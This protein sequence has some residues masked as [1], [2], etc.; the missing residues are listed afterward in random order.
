MRILSIVALLLVLTIPWEHLE[1]QKHYPRNYFR[2][3]VNFPVSLSGSFGELRKNHFHSGID[4]R[5]QGVQGKPVYA[6]ADGYVS[7][8]NISP[9]GFGKALYLT[10]KNGYTSVYGHLKSCAGAI[11]SWIKTQQYKQESFALDTGIPVGLLKVKKGDIIAYSGNSGSSAGPHLHFEIRDSESQDVIDPLLFG[12][13]PA[14]GDPPK[15]S[16]IKIY[17]R[18]EN[19]LVNGKNEALMVPVSGSDGTCKLN[20]SDTVEISGKINFGI[21]TSDNAEGGLKTGINTIDLTVDG[22]EIFSQHMERFAFSETRYANSLMDYPTFIRSKHKIQRSYV[23]PNNKLSIY[24]DVINQGVVTFN[25]TRVHKLRYRVTDDFG[26]VSMLVFWVK[27]RLA[28]RGITNG[29]SGI[30]ASQTFK[31]QTDNHFERPGIRFDVPK[32]ALYEDLA[33]DYFTSPP[34]HGSFSPVYHLQDQFTPLHTFCNLSIR[35]DN[36][37]GPLRSKALIVSVEGGNRFAGRGGKFEN[38]WVTARIREFGNF[39][40]AVDTTCPVIRAV[41]IFN[42]KKVGR[43]SNIMIKVSDNLSGIQSYRGTLNGK[44][45]LMDYDQKNNLLTYSFD[46]RIKSGKNH[47]LLVVTDA[48]GNSAR[49]EANLIR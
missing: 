6:V 24:R 13:V 3:P 43:Q 27:S 42:N 29:S 18:D 1:G 30:K 22:S 23:A 5:T 19:A 20:N 11:G 45:I 46:N 12:F 15:I 40:V 44:W 34:V 14:D 17:P 32:E 33:F 21:E 48:V 7:R 37:P 39:T 25:D 47:F 28:S 16:Y 8:V 2:S 9:I 38:G 10:H 31:Y 49:F 4:I 26:N 35:P 41:N 36:L